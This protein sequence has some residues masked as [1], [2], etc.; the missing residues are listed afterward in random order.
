MNCF[1]RIF[2]Y[3]LGSTYYFQIWLFHVKLCHMSCQNYCR[4]DLQN[5]IMHESRVSNP[6]HICLGC[7][8]NTLIQDFDFAIIHRH[9]PWTWN[10]TCKIVSYPGTKFHES[11]RNHACC[12]S[13]KLGTDEELKFSSVLSLF[14]SDVKNKPPSRELILEAIKGVLSKR[15]LS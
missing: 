2:T 1:S 13:L 9:T 10:I 4:F 11:L 14:A 7:C 15:C 5:N 3:H 8:R 6:H 12:N